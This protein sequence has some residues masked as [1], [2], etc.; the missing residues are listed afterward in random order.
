MAKRNINSTFTRENECSIFVSGRGGG[1]VSSCLNA[2]GA[3]GVSTQGESI[4]IFWQEA[5]APGAFS[6]CFFF[7]SVGCE[8]CERFLHI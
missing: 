2:N 8:V 5:P 1:G 4:H 6:F 3:A 7:F